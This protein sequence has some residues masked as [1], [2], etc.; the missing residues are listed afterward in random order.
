MLLGFISLLLTVLQDYISDICIPKS[1]G[2]TWHP[3]KNGTISKDSKDSTHG[4]KLLQFLDSNFSARRRLATKGDDNCT[5]N[6]IKL[7]DFS[8]FFFFVCFGFSGMSCFGLP[9]LQGKV[10]FMSAYA[11]HQLHVFIFVL[12]VFHVVFC[13]LTLAL[14][15]TKVV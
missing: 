13:I 14:G 5:K 7:S 15:R 12:A 2:A 1:V 3:C 9:I 10:A 8:V 6:V 4:R 11:I